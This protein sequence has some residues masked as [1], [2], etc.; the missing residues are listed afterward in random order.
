MV[1][2]N[3]ARCL[4]CG[5]CADD[6]Y[7][8]DGHRSNALALPE[9]GECSR[10][11]AGVCAVCLARDHACKKCSCGEYLMTEAEV[12]VGECEVCNGDI[13]DAMAARAFGV[14]GRMSAQDEAHALDIDE[15]RRKQ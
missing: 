2:A 15:D 3:E 10:C 6:V 14:L 8:V 1:T 9:V 12:D 11:H 7:D 4:D 13:A 5:I